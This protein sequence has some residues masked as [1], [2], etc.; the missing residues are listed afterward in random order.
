LRGNNA[1]NKVLGSAKTMRVTVKR[2]DLPPSCGNNSILL[3]T[4]SVGVGNPNLM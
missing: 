4:V 1:R 2:L 3:Y